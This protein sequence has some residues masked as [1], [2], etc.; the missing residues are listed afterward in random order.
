MTPPQTPHPLLGFPFKLFVC[1][2]PLPLH[3]SLTSESPGPLIVP[4]FNNFLTSLGRE[5]EGYKVE[6]GFLSSEK[7]RKRE[8]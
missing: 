8:D 1:S 7:V 6:I 2:T 5:K 3:L 4:D